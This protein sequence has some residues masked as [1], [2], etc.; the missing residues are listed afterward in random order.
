M[1]SI[2][3]HYSLFCCKMGAKIE[4]LGKSL[5]NHGLRSNPLLGTH[6]KEVEAMMNNI[7]KTMDIIATPKITTKKEEI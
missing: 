6:W 2:K 5:F 1:F 3:I 4:R 7:Q